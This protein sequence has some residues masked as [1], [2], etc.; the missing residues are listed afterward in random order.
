VKTPLDATPTRCPLKVSLIL[1]LPVVVSQQQWIYLSAPNPN[2]SFGREGDT[3][4]FNTSTF[5]L[6]VNHQLLA[7]LVEL[8]ER[9]L[10][11]PFLFVADV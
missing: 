10:K 7:L 5:F 4:G 8:V 3:A 1:D 2:S 6:R 11:M 9:S